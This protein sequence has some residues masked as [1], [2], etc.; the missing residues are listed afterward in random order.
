MVDVV[1]RIKLLF[2]SQGA[3][4]AAK[5]TERV[6]R[7]QTRLGQAS[8]ASGRQFSAQASGL[9]GLVSVYAGAAANIFA[10]TMAFNALAKAARAEQVVIGTRTLAR[11]IGASGDQIIAKVQEITDGQLSLVETATQLNAA[12]SAGFG[13]KQI[14]RLTL[15]S[16]KASRALGRDLGDAFNRLVRG[17]A[18]LEPELIDELG[19][20]TRIEPAV[21]AYAA[22]NN[23]AATSLTNFERRQA[24]LNAIILEGERKFG[25]IDTSGENAQ[26]SM[27]RLLATLTDLALEFG[28]FIANVLT[29]LIDFFSRAGNQLVLFGAIGLIVFGKLRTVMGTFITQGINRMSTSLNNAFLQMSK[30]SKKAIEE[31]N[32]LGAAADK[33][34]KGAGQ[35]AGLKDP[36]RLGAAEVKR[37]VKEPITLASA[38]R[39]KEVAGPL[40]K[41]LKQMNKL[42]D[43]QRAHLKGL[44]K[45][46]D[47]FETRL[48]SSS[49]LTR[50]FAVS[51]GRAATAVKILGIALKGLMAVLN[52]VMMVVGALQLVLSFFDIDL[53]KVIKDL[54]VDSSQEAKNYK[55]GL[56]ALASQTLIISGVNDELRK[57]LGLSK[58]SFKE[59]TAA[60]KEYMIAYLKAA[61]IE[62]MTLVERLATQ[63]VD[64]LTNMELLG[65][66]LLKGGAS[67][68]TLMSIGAAIIGPTI[69]L[70]AAEQMLNVQNSI[71]A[72]MEK[73]KK[74]LAELATTGKA[75][76]TNLA[77]LEA[78]NAAIKN[79][80]D[81]AA[82]GTRTVASLSG[83]FQELGMSEKRAVEIIKEFVRV[84][85]RL[86]IDIPNIVDSTKGWVLTL[87]TQEAGYKKLD[88]RLIKVALATGNLLD[89]QLSL[90]EQMKSGNMTAEQAAAAF[91]A[92][93]NTAT[94]LVDEIRKL[95]KTF[96]MVETNIRG[97]IEATQINIQYF[98]N[99]VRSLKVVEDT[100]R[101]VRSVFSS[102]IKE[103]DQLLAKGKLTM[104]SGGVTTT[105]LEQ[106]SSQLAFLKKSADLQGAALQLK[107]Q[108]QG[109]DIAR[110][111]ATEEHDTRT[112]AELEKWKQLIIESH[113]MESSFLMRRI[114]LSDAAMKSLVSGYIKAAAEAAK[115]VLIQ[116]K[117]NLKLEGTLTKLKSKLQLQEDQNRL[118]ILKAEQ[119]V[120]MDI[121]QTRVKEIEMNKAEGERWWKA[122]IQ[123]AEIRK[124]VAESLQEAVDLERQLN[125]LTTERNRTLAKQGELRQQNLLAAEAARL[126]AMGSMATPEQRRE[127][128][129][130]IVEY[131]YQLTMKA[132]D[133]KQSLIVQEYGRS[134]EDIKRR[135]EVLDQEEKIS[136]GKYWQATEIYWRDS[137]LA[138][139][140]FDIENKKIADRQAQMVIEK[141]IALK[142]ADAA[143]TNAY[144]ARQARDFEINQMRKKVEFLK[145]QQD[146]NKAFL[147]GLAEFL[148]GFGEQVYLLGL[149]Q[150]IVPTEIVE[151]GKEQAKKARDE[152]VGQFGVDVTTLESLITK[153][154]IA[155]Q[156][157]WRTQLEGIIE[158]Y[159]T[160]ISQLEIEEAAIIATQELNQKKWL[161][162]HAAAQAALTS[163][164]VIRDADVAAYDQKVKNLDFEKKIADEQGSAALAEL[165]LDRITAKES[166]AI[167]KRKAAAERDIMLQLGKEITTLL[168]DKIGGGIQSLFKALR[169]GTLTM[170]NFKEGAKD[171]ALDILGGIQEK[172]IEEFLVKPVED[173][174]SEAMS[175][176]FGIEKVEVHD[177]S[178]EAKALYVRDVKQEAIFRDY[179]EKFGATGG[180]FQN[181]VDQQGRE[182]EHLQKLK[183]PERVEGVSDEKYNKFISNLEDLRTEF[184]RTEREKSGAVPL[185]DFAATKKQQNLNEIIN[186][187]K[188]LDN[189]AENAA[190]AIS[191][192]RK[193]LVDVQS[194]SEKAATD[195]TKTATVTKEQAFLT[196]DQL[197]GIGIGAVATFGTI[198]AA[199][200]DFKKSMIATFLQMFTQI[201]LMAAQSEMSGGSSSGG[202]L[203]DFFGGL[204]SGGGGGAASSG[205][206]LQSTISSGSMIMAS[207]GSVRKFAAGGVMQR[208]SVPAL[209]EPGE[210]VIRKPMAKAIGGPALQRMNGT[211]QMSGGNVE[212]T[213]INKGTPQKAEAKEKP[214]FDGKGM[215]IEIVLT[216]LKNN[217]PIK[218]AIR[219]GGRR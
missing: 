203:F 141:D 153:A 210:F 107:L 53:F 81:L 143:A 100:A 73:E 105:P 31:A 35:L 186:Q 83:A 8:A 156:A 181:Y 174:I 134:M 219:G 164:E 108:L 82:L 128:E 49:K 110:R 21:Q 195:V 71:L 101:T 144:V 190:P 204:F 22:A 207:G 80:E 151:K 112:L 17:A 147:T 185:L 137:E 182:W 106:R 201:A 145:T 97:V 199:T 161:E 68:Q 198:Y 197:T 157:I 160:Q 95:P 172:L 64:V 136:Q 126:E 12:L 176:I 9:G 7:A 98:G 158:A 19:I 18:K 45:A 118:K 102:A 90:N 188:N 39:G 135:K 57:S 76:P 26:K 114:E 216:D 15:V 52:V 74:L 169:E 180:D 94:K 155:N 86:T 13:E 194:A 162:E 55:T 193:S 24:F 60:A 200:G 178:S 214:K 70:T 6:G 2:V 142:T 123:R 217:G 104:D 187:V 115:L 127:A 33:A 209:L 168:Q 152:I 205:I 91:D 63:A 170:D 177:G 131:E 166:L 218:Q 27:E 66:A 211:G 125:D 208:D 167:A 48:K 148:Q 1:S 99:L 59:A 173:L 50:F 77:E 109:I 79:I 20:F 184:L 56:E 3:E 41:D 213:L 34:F 62:S 43:N 10:L 89:R 65:E 46:H 150:G 42:T 117:Y 28:Q 87:D 29:P 192:V 16:L 149:S 206:P 25:N 69:D 14:E 154:D 122:A 133:R 96:S 179:M 138:D 75:T 132:I 30:G 78:L 130:N 38:I 116:E 159:D 11:E 93:K 146:V 51:M 111:Q 72:T 139:K 84:G 103:A 47:A 36:G 183:F 165:E 40:I 120:S 113:G 171:L 58:D 175:G 23:V 119:K 212:V 121:L 67:V 44:T 191:K 215:V 140:N 61:E 92:Y 5:Q 202:G 37:I 54:F 85:E 163:A 88:S 196:N 189:A 4:K 129:L 32:N 124:D